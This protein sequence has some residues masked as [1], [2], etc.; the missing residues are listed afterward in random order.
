MIRVFLE[1][2]ENV[3]ALLLKMILLKHRFLPSSRSQPTA[4]RLDHALH[5]TGARA[6]RHQIG[7]AELR[8]VPGKLS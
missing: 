6:E 7:P 2:D 8:D 4:Q 1:H 3:H 5:D